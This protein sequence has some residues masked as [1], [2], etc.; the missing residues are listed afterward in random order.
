LPN[1]KKQFK[2]LLG[3]DIIFFNK[4]EKKPEHREESLEHM[5][6]CGCDKCKLEGLQ[7]LAQ[8]NRDRL[9]LDKKD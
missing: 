8:A 6:D 7:K 5:D 4:V 2:E 3:E 9:R 1:N